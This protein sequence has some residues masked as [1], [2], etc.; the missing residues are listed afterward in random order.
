MASAAQIEANRNNSKRSTGPK[1]KKGKSKV[2]LNALTH[3]GRAKVIAV[4]PVLPQEDPKVLEERIQSWLDDWQP[5]DEIEAKLV[6]YGAKLSWLLERSERVEAAHLSHRVRK[7]MRKAGATVPARQVKLVNDLGRKLF[8]NYKPG[9]LSSPAP[10]WDDEPAVVVARLEESALGCRW[11]LDRWVEFRLRVER[12]DTWLPP[13]VY[14]FVRLLGK[15]GYEAVNDP[16]LNAIF[17]ALDVLKVGEAEKQWKIHTWAMAD[18]ELAFCGCSVWRELGPRPPDVH[19]A[20][21][22][23]RAVVAERIERLEGIV[24]EFKQIAE[25]EA[26]EAADRAA[27]DP[28]PAFDRH[29]RHQ[30]SLGRELLRTVDT[31]RRLLKVEERPSTDADQNVP[32]EEAANEVDERKNATN[33]ANLESTQESVEMEV[34]SNNGNCEDDEQSQSAAPQGGPSMDEIPVLSSTNEAH[35]ENGRNGSV[36]HE[37]EDRVRDQKNATNKANLEST[38][39]SAEMEVTSNNGNCEDNEQSQSEADGRSSM[40][41]G[42]R[43]WLARS[44]RGSVREAEMWRRAAGRSRRKPDAR[45]QVAGRSVAFQ[46]LAALGSA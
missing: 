17:V 2:R 38:Q 24:A 18:R 12:R 37:G 30:A 15:R 13:E 3:G 28:S 42:S 33:K 36:S 39:E 4:M 7:A 6:C 44:G 34:T 9:S 27:F 19:S 26:A 43:R 46:D 1:T 41:R 29:R 14:R 45:R 23:L 31:L 11:L 8:Y 22:V 21:E 40:T 16:S 32:A 25:A 35:E 10:A 5:R 20:L